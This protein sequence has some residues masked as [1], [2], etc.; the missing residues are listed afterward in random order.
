MLKKF[1]EF[2]AG[3]LFGAFLAKS[4]IIFG[5]ASERVRMKYQKEFEDS[6]TEKES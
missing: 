5:I 6:K 2:G 4:S 1:A 3:I